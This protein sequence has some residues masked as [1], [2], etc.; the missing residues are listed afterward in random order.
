MIDTLSVPH[1][2]DDAD[3]G[4]L[5][6][7]TLQSPPDNPRLNVNADG[8]LFT[9]RS[10]LRGPDGDK[11][12]LE[13]GKEFTRLLSTGTGMISFFNLSLFKLSIFNLSLF[14][15]T[16]FRFGNRPP[17]GPCDSLGNQI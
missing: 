3:F 1:L 13:Q 16:I 9:M 10:A 4:A 7:S 5:A 15:L 14:K 8:T 2:T 17:A 11:W 6:N 12:E